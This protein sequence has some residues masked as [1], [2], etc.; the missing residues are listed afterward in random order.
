MLLNLLPTMR[1]Q[2]GL[3]LKAAFWDSS[4]Q[5]AV[6]LEEDF[7]MKT[8]EQFTTIPKL[9]LTNEAIR[10]TWTDYELSNGPVEIYKS[11]T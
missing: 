4:E 5:T 8:Y 11:I 1:G 6:N 9:K 2:H 3:S 10:H 7:D